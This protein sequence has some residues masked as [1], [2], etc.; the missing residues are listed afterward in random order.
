LGGSEVKQKEDIGGIM[1]AIAATGVEEAKDARKVVQQIVFLTAVFSTLLEVLYFIGLAGKLIIDGT[2]HSTSSQSVQ[3]ISAV[4][5][6]LLN[7]TLLIMFVALRRQMSGRDVLF[8]DLACVFMMLVCLTSSVNWFVQL[9]IVPRLVQAGDPI[10]TLIDV[11]N[12]SSLM[13]AVE[14]LGWGVFY[15]LATIFIAIAMSGGKLESWI[16]W[17]FVAG[18][19][20]SLLH[21]FGIITTNLAMSDLG[22]VAWGILLPI[23]TTLIAI[24]S[25]R[26]YAH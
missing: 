1:Q 19:I 5:G 26:S 10:V 7:I 13:Y 24:R 6:I 21:V 8:A 15:G 4:V 12:N 17:L 25:Q 3:I 11:H 14:H 9:A 20:L 23:T 22:Y 2:V 18:G 16:G